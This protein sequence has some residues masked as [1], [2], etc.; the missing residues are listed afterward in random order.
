MMNVVF[1][2]VVTI[3]VMTDPL[4]QHI[5]PDT[6]HILVVLLVVL[7]VCTL[8]PVV[9]VVEFR[10]LLFLKTLPDGVLLFG[11]LIVCLQK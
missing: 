9:V 8:L 10:N 3:V 1:I 11:D 5:A 4:A 7:L 2:I 6:P